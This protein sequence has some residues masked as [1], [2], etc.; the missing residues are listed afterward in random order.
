MKGQVPSKTY[1]SKQ[2]FLHIADF[3]SPFFENSSNPRIS[4]DKII[5][6]LHFHLHLGLSLL[7]WHVVVVIAFDEEYVN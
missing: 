3:H 5:S 1:L 4:H 2:I 7:I 6:L